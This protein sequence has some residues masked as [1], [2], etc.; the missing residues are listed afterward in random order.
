[1]DLWSCDLMPGLV[2]A[3][4]VVYPS[5]MNTTSLVQAA[6]LGVNVCLRSQLHESHLVDN[7]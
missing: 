7:K 3:A 5:S 4:I 2:A 1:M 6:E